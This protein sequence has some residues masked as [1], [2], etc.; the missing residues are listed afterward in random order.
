[1]KF[2]NFSSTAALAVALLAASANAGYPDEADGHVNRRLPAG[3]N[4]NG[5]GQGQGNGKPGA[6]DDEIGVIVVWKNANG[7]NELNNFAKDQKVNDI[8][9]KLG[10]SALKTFRGNWNALKN[11]P[12]FESVEIDAEVH[13]LPYFRGGNDEES[14]HQQRRLAEEAP[15]GVAQVQADQLSGLPLPDPTKKK[16]VCVVDTGY[17]LGHEDLPDASYGVNGYLPSGYSGS[18]NV[19]GDGHG[20]HCAGTIG[21]IGGN[22]KGV[23]SVNPDPSKFSFF[24]GKG[25]QDNGSGSTSGVM[26]A[27]TACKDNGANVISMSL[28]GGG[29]TNAENSLYEDL[30]KNDDVLIIAAAGNDVSQS[31]TITFLLI[32]AAKTYRSHML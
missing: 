4:G 30:Y 27:V 26:E 16:T 8:S 15:Y 23:T 24:I 28:G 7:R 29:E 13:A 2:A 12:N 10:I 19:D 9:S 21:A 14:D 6:D 1:M 20:T 31:R 3:G 18:W 32:H 22:G 11:N 25:L 17:A 5:Q